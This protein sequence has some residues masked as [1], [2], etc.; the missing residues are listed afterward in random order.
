MKK[1]YLLPVV[2]FWGC[3]PD[4]FNIDDNIYNSTLEQCGYFNAKCNEAKNLNGNLKQKN[5]SLEAVNQNLN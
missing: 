1:V 5:A 3:I 2:L 4:D